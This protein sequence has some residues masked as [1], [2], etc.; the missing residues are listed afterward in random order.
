MLVIQ[1]VGNPIVCKR[2]NMQLIFPEPY[3][4]SIREIKI[5]SGKYKHNVDEFLLK[6]ECS[7]ISSLF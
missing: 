2:N 6:L 5:K 7:F 4:F 1:Y 3:I